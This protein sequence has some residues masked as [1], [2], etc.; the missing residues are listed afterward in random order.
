MSWDNQ[1]MSIT[2]LRVHSH[3]S[4]L[5]ALPQ[6]PDLIR[7]AKEYNYSSLALTDYNNMYGAI[8]FYKECKNV[9]IKPI[10]GVETYIRDE[11]GQKYNLV[12]LAKNEPGYK[13]LMKI[14]SLISLESD[15]PA[16]TDKILIKEA[17]DLIILSGGPWGDISKL[18]IHNESRALDR[19]KFYQSVV[20]EDDFYL[21]VTPHLFMDY[22]KEM[23]QK[24]I[25]FA[26]KNKIK[27]G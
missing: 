26:K 18:L 23:R 2:P 11:E 20:S 27:I 3:Y 13:S 19:V 12:L 25:D 24:T 7:R 1:Y 17:K 10:L 4:L 8:E 21:E 14:I 22:G 15:E 9:G 16:L 5:K 6:L